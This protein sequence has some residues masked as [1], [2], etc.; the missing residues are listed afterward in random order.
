M[1]GNTSEHLRTSAYTLLNVTEARVDTLLLAEQKGCSCHWRQYSYDVMPLDAK[2]VW[3][4]A[5][6]SQAHGLCFDG[7]TLGRVPFHGEDAGLCV[8][9]ATSKR[10]TFMMLLAT[11]ALESQPH[12][13]VEANA[14]ELASRFEE[15]VQR[16]ISD[17]DAAVLER[18]SGTPVPELVQDVLAVAQERTEPAS[19]TLLDSL[20][21]AVRFVPHA[22]NSKGLHLLRVVLAERMID[23]RRD[24][25]SSH[26][27]DEVRAL[28]VL[29]ERDGF[30]RLNAS[31]YLSQGIATERL[32]Q[33][34]AQ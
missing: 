26:F 5:G 16:H 13:R 23:A 17:N 25:M 34:P 29:W 9:S 12:A 3:L 28:R 15:L 24:S 7:N 6:S 31:R 18:V 1:L 22:L 4:A 14:R 21:S 19:V 27:S 8:T 11:R 2:T 10:G 32:N 20:L 30:L 33:V